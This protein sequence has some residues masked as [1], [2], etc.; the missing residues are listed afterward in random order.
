MERP[1]SEHDPALKLVHAIERRGLADHAAEVGRRGI[2]I[3]WIHLRAVRQVDGV[4]ALF[5]AHTL[6]KFG[7]A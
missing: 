4:A 5:E 3:R 7:L 2:Q 6:A 1:L